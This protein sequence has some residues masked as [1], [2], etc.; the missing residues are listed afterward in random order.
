MAGRVEIGAKLIGLLDELIYGK[1]SNEGL[2]DNENED[3]IYELKNLFNTLAKRVGGLERHRTDT[4]RRLENLEGEEDEETYVHNHP[5]LAGLIDELGIRITKLETEH[6][7]KLTGTSGQCPNCG[8]T[9]IV[10]VK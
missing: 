7:Q 10:E 3:D 1:L 2:L 8:H 9:F 6:K 5:D 4:L